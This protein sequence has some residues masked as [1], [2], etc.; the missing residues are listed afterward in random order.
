MWH[1]RPVEDRA[2]TPRSASERFEE[3]L[4]M[5]G[6]ELAF[7]DDGVDL[8]QIRAALDRTPLERF[9]HHEASVRSVRWML[10]AAAKTTR[11]HVATK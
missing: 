8:T 3:K 2:P 5:H 6:P 7:N 4:A 9:I 10:D 11:P 1:D